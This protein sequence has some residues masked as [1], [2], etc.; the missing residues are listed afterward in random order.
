M[1]T[2]NKMR[3][4]TTRMPITPSAIEPVMI[5]MMKTALFS[6]FIFPLLDGVLLIIQGVSEKNVHSEN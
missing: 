5:I 2:I 3:P 6:L 1:N 4:M